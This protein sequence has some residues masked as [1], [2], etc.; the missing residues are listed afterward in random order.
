MTANENGKLTAPFLKIYADKGH[1]KN[2]LSL[3]LNVC[4]C[5]KLL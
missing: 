3:K 2:I 1:K 4:V 5:E